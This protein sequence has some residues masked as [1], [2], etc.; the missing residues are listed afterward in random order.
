MAK[1]AKGMNKAK[2]LKDAARA[3][4]QGQ[5][6]AGYRPATEPHRK[7]KEVRKDRRRDWSKEF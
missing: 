7:V 1:N 2:D 5:L 4:A 3:R 6:L